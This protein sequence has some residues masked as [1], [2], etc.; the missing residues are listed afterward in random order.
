MLLESDDVALM[1]HVKMAQAVIDAYPQGR[2]AGVDEFWYV[3]SM[4]Q[5]EMH[6][7]DLSTIWTLREGDR[8]PVPTI[9][10]PT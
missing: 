5:P 9:W 3:S 4:L 2:S 8:F 7:L 6:F 1:N 10:P